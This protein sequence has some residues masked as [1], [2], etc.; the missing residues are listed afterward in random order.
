MKIVVF[1]NKW[2]FVNHCKIPKGKLDWSFAIDDDIVIMYNLTY[3][4]AEKEAIKT[5]RMKNVNTVELLP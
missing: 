2:K 4:Q 3:L 1:K 5:A